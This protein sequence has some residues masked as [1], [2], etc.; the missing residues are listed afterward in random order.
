MTD[1]P[2]QPAPRPAA[3]AARVELEELLQGVRRELARR[4]EDP[5]GAWVEESAAELATGAK[6][7]WFL[8]GP[9][10]GIAFYA[11]R[12]PNAFGHLHTT[13]GLD[14]ARRLSTALVR[15]LPADIASVD[16]GFTGLDP[17]QERLL[18][19]ELSATPGSTVIGRRAMERPLQPADG[20]LP[21]SPPPGVE[22]LPVSAVTTEALVELDRAAFRDS[23]DALL[24]GGEPGA[25]RD[26]LQAMLGGRFGRFLGEASTTL[27]EPEPTRLVG[28]VLS[29][30]RSSRRAIV[31]DLVVDPARRRR[32][33]G[34]FLLGWTVRALW[35]LGYESAR[36]WVSVRNTAALGLYREFGFHAT[37]E[38]TIYRWDRPGSTAQPHSAR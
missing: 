28:A 35:A 29:A 9:E 27:V 23:V 12:G 7:G 15:H 26:A 20:R 16:L 31:L 21:S 19:E 18:A 36:L 13:A 4:D 1:G 30:E 10:G 3:G 14:A 17:G 32:G 37:L 22:R 11:R 34:R 33:L 8:A 24:L 38:A 25:Y 6:P 5:A 2:E